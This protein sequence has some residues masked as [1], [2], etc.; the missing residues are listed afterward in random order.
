MYIEYNFWIAIEFILLAAIIIP[1]IIVFFSGAPWVPT[2]LPRVKRMLELAEI[3]P[4]QR[5]YDL[6]CGDGRTVHLA[7]K[8]YNADAKGLELSPLIFFAALVRNFV[9]RSKSKILFRDFRRIN[10]C[11]ADALLFYLLPGILKT[12]RPK[13][14]AELKPG[15][16]VVSYAFAIEGWNPVYVEPR[17]PQKN[18]GPIFVYRMPESTLQRQIHIGK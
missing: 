6:G 5:V 3:K 4:G 10:Y 12:M 18:Y 14:E 2:P 9:L 17:N 8:L 15:T 16:R 7:S 11:D 13:F 1:T